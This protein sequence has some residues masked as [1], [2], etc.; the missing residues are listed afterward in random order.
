MK[1]IASVRKCDQ[2]PRVRNRFHERENPFRRERFGSPETAPAS[3]IKE[4]PS[5]FLARSSSVRIILPF[6]SFVLRDVCS[7]HSSS[8]AVIRIVIVRLIW[9][10]C[11]TLIVLGQISDRQVAKKIRTQRL[12]RLCLE[13]MQSLGKPSCI[14]AFLTSSFLQKMKLPI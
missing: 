5:V 6:L 7:S 11:N 3:L 13:S 14:T 10:N 1:T 9:H 2:K 8:S 4:R 12:L